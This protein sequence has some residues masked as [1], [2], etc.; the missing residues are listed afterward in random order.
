VGY[1]VKRAQMQAKAKAKLEKQ[2]E[3]A[4]QLAEAKLEKEKAWRT[5]LRNQEMKRLAVVREEEEKTKRA[6][7]ARSALLRHWQSGCWK[8]CMEPDTVARTA[9]P[10]R[11]DQIQASQQFCLNMEIQP[12]VKAGASAYRNDSRRSKSSMQRSAQKRRKHAQRHIA[13]SR[14]EFRRRSRQ[15]WRRSGF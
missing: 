2:N 1:E 10:A 5:A 11:W 4:R 3:R 9:K 15:G 13:R 12:M 14:S 6:D 7:K 8:S